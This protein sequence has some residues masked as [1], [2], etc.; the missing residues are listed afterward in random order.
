MSYW[1]I[2]FNFVTPPPQ[3]VITLATLLEQTLALT[4]ISLFILRA[5]GAGVSPCD[6]NVAGDPQ[7]PQ[8]LLSLGQH[9][10]E[11]PEPHFCHSGAD[12]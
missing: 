12:A 9:A 10:P 4:N 7:P 11:D 5:A 8:H 1:V 6:L 2:C 3:I